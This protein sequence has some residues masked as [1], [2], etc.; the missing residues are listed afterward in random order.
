MICIEGNASRIAPA[1][2]GL[3]SL[4]LSDPRIHFGLESDRVD[5]AEVRSAL[6]HRSV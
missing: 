2:G 1:V 4:T 3:F 5:W 6:E